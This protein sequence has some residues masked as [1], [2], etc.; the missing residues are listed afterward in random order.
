MSLGLRLYYLLCKFGDVCLELIDLFALASVRV[1]EVLI[2]LVK[3][4]YL[5][6]KVAELIFLA[7][8]KGT[9]RRSIL[10]LPSLQN[11]I[12][13]LEQIRSVCTYQTHIFSHLTT[14]FNVPLRRSRLASISNLVVRIAG[15]TLRYE[16]DSRAN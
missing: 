6:R 5:L 2:F 11:L 16:H 13:R 4:F 9:L 8:S 1:T 3:L 10:F 14:R 15:S 12:V 7:L